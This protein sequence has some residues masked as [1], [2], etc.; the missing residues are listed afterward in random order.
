MYSLSSIQ[1][2]YYVNFG[3]QSSI[4]ILLERLAVR[5]YP[6]YVGRRVALSYAVEIEA[7]A[8]GHFDI[9]GRGLEDNRLT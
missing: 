4:F 6:R 2:N 8:D 7:I 9:L 1:V 5:S 3:E